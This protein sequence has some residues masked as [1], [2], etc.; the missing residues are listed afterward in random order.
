MTFN[1]FFELFCFLAAV[2]LCKII[3]TLSNPAADLMN[4]VCSCFLQLQIPLYWNDS[5]LALDLSVMDE[6]GEGRWYY[7]DP[8]WKYEIW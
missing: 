1:I 5:R 4:R 6:V 2:K 7:L 8:D 3:K